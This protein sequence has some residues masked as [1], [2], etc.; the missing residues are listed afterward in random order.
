MPCLFT[1]LFLISFIFWIL[2]DHPNILQIYEVWETD[3]VCSIVS[4]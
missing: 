1:T 4:Q 3:D 2:Q